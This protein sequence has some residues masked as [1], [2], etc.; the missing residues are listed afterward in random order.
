MPPERAAGLLAESKI[1]AYVGG[2]PRFPGDVPASLRTVESLGG[3]VIVEPDD[4]ART[5]RLAPHGTLRFAIA[6]PRRALTTRAARR[7][8]P[9]QVA[10]ADYARGCARCGAIVAALQAGDHRA[11]GRAIEGSLTD[12]ARAALIPGFADVCASA[13]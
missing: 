5:V 9:R 11:L 7:A 2:A 10:L 8:L 12:R 4:P 13:R 3:F 1:Q 6:T